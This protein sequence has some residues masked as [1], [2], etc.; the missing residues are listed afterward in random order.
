M[1]SGKFE[2]DAEVEVRLDFAIQSGVGDYLE[3]KRWALDR[4][5]SDV[6]W[7]LIEREGKA[8]FAFRRYPDA[9]LFALSFPAAAIRTPGA[10]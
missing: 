10:I 2:P 1:V 3:A 6:R 9:L 8:V 5:G 4:F 7:Q